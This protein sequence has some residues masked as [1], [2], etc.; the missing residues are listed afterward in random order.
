MSTRREFIHGSAAVAGASLANSVMPKANAESHSGSRKKPNIL[1]LYTEGVRWDAIGVNS[2]AESRPFAQ[3][4]NM[5]RICKEGVNFQNAFCTNALCGPSRAVAMTGMYSHNT[6]ALG[7]RVAKP[8]PASIPVF[9]DLLKDEGYDCA[10]IGKAHGPMGFR[11]RYWDYY[12]AFNAPSTNYYN[13]VVYEGSKGKIPNETKVYENIYADDLFTD[14]ALE[15][16]KGQKSDERPFCLC[17]WHQTPHAPFYRP[18]KYLNL[19]NGMPVPVPATWD[20]DLKGYPGKPRAFA[21][22]HNKIGTQPN[23]DATRSLEEIY[24]D[25]YAGLKDVDDN[26]GRVLTYLESISELDNTIIMLSSDH[27]YFLGEWRC[28]DKRFMHEPSS[29]IPMAVRY[30]KAF[31]AGTKVDGQVLNLDCV[32]TLLELAGVRIPEAVDGRSFVR[33]AQDTDKNWRK[34]WLYE[35]FEYPAGQQVRPHRGV[36][37]ERYKYIHYFADPQEFELYD[38]QSDPGEL[39]NLAGLPQHANLQKDLATRLTELRKESRDTT[40]DAIDQAPLVPLNKE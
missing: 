19:F 15:W 26:V 20:D 33:L 3:T 22:A 35:Y 11:D 28:F 13:A 29:K 8:L 4:P 38:L 12:C 30:P 7:N 25:Y 2:T 1:F 24:K 23:V 6:G 27:G 9:T 5:D 40:T 14:K 34:D 32:P 36:R 16:L 10:M 18:R 37:T 31:R 39:N 17:L 21:N